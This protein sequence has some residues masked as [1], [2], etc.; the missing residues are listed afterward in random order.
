LVRLPQIKGK[1]WRY[2]DRGHAPDAGTPVQQGLF[3]GFSGFGTGI[4]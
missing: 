2:G 3:T 4:A 1:L